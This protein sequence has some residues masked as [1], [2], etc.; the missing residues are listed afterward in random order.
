MFERSFSFAGIPLLA[1]AQ[2]GGPRPC[3][4]LYHGL[5][6]DKETHRKELTSLAERG[7]LALGVD[8]IAHG[9]RR[10]PDLQG[11]LGRGEFM[12]QLGKLLR[13]TLHE[14][15]LLIDFLEAE[16]YGPF[17]LCGISLGGLL[18]FAAP[19]VESRLRA[20]VPILADP[21]WC[22]PWEQLEA[23]RSVPIFAWNG[24]RDTHVDSGPTRALLEQLQGPRHR[25]QEYPESDHFFREEDWNHAWGETLG[26]FERFLKG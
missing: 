8:F 20:L 7:F 17:G 15:P 21:N 6:S 13:P 10:M 22:N 14:L 12:A 19:Q 3:V 26:W 25:F 5:H 24:G 9:Q 11:F 4:L 1:V 23:Y 2:E 18:A 16:G